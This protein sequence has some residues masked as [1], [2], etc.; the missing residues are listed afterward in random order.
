VN[1]EGAVKGNHRLSGDGGGVDWA[2]AVGG[3]RVEVS[4]SRQSRGA[5]HVKVL[6]VVE[7]AGVVLV[8]LKHHGGQVVLKMAMV[9]P[10]AWIVG[11]NSRVDE[12]ARWQWDDI[13]LRWFLEVEWWKNTVAVMR[14]H[15]L[16]II[17]VDEGVVDGESG[18]WVQ[19]GFAL[20]KN[21]EGVS[22]QMDGMSGI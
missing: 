11:V 4:A 12:S 15:A 13:L 5:V 14:L 8:P 20:E 1:G 19:D 17:A 2:N 16:V 9:G 3:I 10:C 6:R 22:V 7:G 18:D 21:P